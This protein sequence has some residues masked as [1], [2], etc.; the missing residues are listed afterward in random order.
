MKKL[1]KG[2]MTAVEGVLW[3]TIFFLLFVLL[4]SIGLV[5]LGIDPA[6]AEVEHWPLA[7]VDVNA[8]SYL[9]VRKTP[10]GELRTVRLESLAEVLVLDVKDGWALVIRPEHLGNGDM[11]GTPLGWVCMEYL[12]IY[13]DYMVAAK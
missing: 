9:N 1:R 11:N 10:A 12:R 6:C 4:Y 13:R 5:A 3:V 8:D 7:Y 2:L